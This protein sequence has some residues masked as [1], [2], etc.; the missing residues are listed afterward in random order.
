MFIGRKTP[1]SQEVSTSHLGSM[2]QHNLSQHFRK[3]FCRCWQTVLKSYIEKQ[4][5]PGGGGGTGL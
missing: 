2:F 5:K 1:Y 4:K 3:L